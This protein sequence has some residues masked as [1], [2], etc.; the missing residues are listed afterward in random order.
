[1]GG[2]LRFLCHQDDDWMT[3]CLCMKA[4]KWE[5]RVLCTV[6]ALWN[7]MRWVWHS[8]FPILTPIKICLNSGYWIVQHKFSHL[9]P[10]PQAPTSTPHELALRAH[11]HGAVPTVIKHIWP[12]FA[13]LVRALA[14]STVH[15][16]GPS[17][18]GRS[19]L[20]HGTVAQSNV[21]VTYSQCTHSSLQPF[22]NNGGCDSIA[23]KPVKWQSPSLRCPPLC[24]S[25][26]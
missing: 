24:C 5:N 7:G 15:F 11:S 1:M 12:Q 2:D 23:T 4:G 16:L 17:T 18:V 25:R 21:D 13:W 10:L 8:T 22:N 26:S 3:W 9:L 19:G 20:C 14:R 6:R